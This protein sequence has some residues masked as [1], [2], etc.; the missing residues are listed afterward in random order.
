[1]AAEDKM[2]H[3]ES[4]ERNGCGENL[5]MH[6]DTDL[7]STSNKAVQM[8]Y[9]EID[10][11]G[12]DFKEP[13]FDAG[14]GHFTQVVWKGTKFLGCGVNGKYVACHYCDAGNV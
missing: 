11:P 14:T 5:A 12:Y 1:M 4:E 10:D 8:W 7:I 2:Y 6:S 9:Q 13:G 3:S